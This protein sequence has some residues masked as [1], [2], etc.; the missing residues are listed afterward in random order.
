MIRHTLTWDEHK[1]LFIALIISSSTLMIIGTTPVHEFSHWIMSKVDPYIEPV[2]IHI[3]ANVQNIKPEN[4]LFSPL[5]YVIIE[6]EYP[7]AFQERPYVW[8]TIQELV[9]V[10]IQIVITIF[11][12][13]EFIIYVSK[14][15]NTI[16]SYS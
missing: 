16:K 7:G 6:E 9:C 3:F 13:L 11:V 4:V 5:G 15:K 14:D 8:D 12:S 1:I 2:E 10:S